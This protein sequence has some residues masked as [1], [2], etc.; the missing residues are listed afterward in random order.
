MREALRIQTVP[1]DYVLP[2][3]P[4]LGAKFKLICNGVP[5]V[6]ARAVAEAVRIFLLQ[7]P[8]A[9]EDLNQSALRMQELRHNGTQRG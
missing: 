3:E 8:K 1:D 2:K 4:S 6:M 7:S 9:V 5:C